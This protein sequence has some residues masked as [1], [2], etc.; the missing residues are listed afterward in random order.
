MT[1]CHTGGDSGGYGCWQALTYALKCSCTATWMFGG[2][3]YGFRKLFPSSAM[4]YCRITTYS[5]S[6]LLSTSFSAS[7]VFLGLSDYTTGLALSKNLV[8]WCGETSRNNPMRIR[9][10]FAICPLK[11]YSCSG[12]PV[13]EDHLD[14]T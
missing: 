13:V 5:S 6:Q 9:N 11:H 10:M 4:V 2:N 12:Q 8:G 7:S 14:Y 3:S 1:W